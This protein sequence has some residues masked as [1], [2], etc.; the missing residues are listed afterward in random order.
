M[1]TTELIGPPSQD[2]SPF[3]FTFVEYLLSL[4]WEVRLVY[5]IAS[6]DGYTEIS[7][8]CCILKRLLAR[9]SKV[10]DIEVIHY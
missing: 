7:N 3:I 1:L 2:E 5:S 9:H 4:G 6:M 10:L 8:I